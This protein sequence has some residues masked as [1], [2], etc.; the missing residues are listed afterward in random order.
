MGWCFRFK[1]SL[2]HWEPKYSLLPKTLIKGHHFALSSYGS[3][4]GMLCPTHA[5]SI[6]STFYITVYTQSFLKNVGNHFEILWIFQFCQIYMAWI[7][8]RA[9][10]KWALLFIHVNPPR[11]SKKIPAS[12]VIYLTPSVGDKTCLEFVE[13]FISNG[14]KSPSTQRNCVVNSVS[15]SGTC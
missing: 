3:L 12:K 9:R 10:Y 1:P 8:I 4:K 15:C 2:V 11:R 7:Q 5:Q 6:L 14:T 13:N